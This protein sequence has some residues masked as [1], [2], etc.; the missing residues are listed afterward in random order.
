MILIPVHGIDLVYESPS[1]R[2][3]IKTL[4]E[5]KQD[6]PPGPTEKPSSG[7][8]LCLFPPAQELDAPWLT[9][10]ITN[11]SIL[12]RK[13]ERQKLKDFLTSI[14]CAKSDPFIV[15]VS[16]PNA[17]GGLFEKIEKEPF[18]RCIYK[19]IFL[20]YTFSLLKIYTK[21][22]IDKARMSPVLKGNTA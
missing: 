21:E 17:P 14:L 10:C 5:K 4:I 12:F 15:M 3:R 22:E 6:E 19:T 1:L 9:S 8:S 18:E 13:F 16:T 7:V 11:D 20:D 2:E